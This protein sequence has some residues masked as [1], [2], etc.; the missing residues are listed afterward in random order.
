MSFDVYRKSQ[1]SNFSKGILRCLVFDNESKGK[2][3]VP[4]GLFVKEYK[5]IAIVTLCY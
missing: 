3:K 4:S 1:D 5:V 2:R